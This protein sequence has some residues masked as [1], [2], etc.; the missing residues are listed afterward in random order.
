MYVQVP[1]VVVIKE[2][3][4]RWEYKHTEMLFTTVRTLSIGNQIK[5]I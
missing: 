4:D 5:T 3:I 1:T 2:N